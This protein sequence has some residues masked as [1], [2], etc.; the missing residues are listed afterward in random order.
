[1]LIKLWLGIKLTF[2]ILI[3]E[4]V[5]INNFQKDLKLNPKL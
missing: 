3:I 1:M 5:R 2:L 4:N